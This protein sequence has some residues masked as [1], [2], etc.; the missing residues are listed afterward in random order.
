MAFCRFR[1]LGA[2]QIGSHVAIQKFDP[3]FLFVF[4]TRY[5]CKMQLLKVIP[6]SFIV[7]YG[8]MLISTTRGRLRPEMR[9]PVDR[10]TAVF[11]S[12]FV[13]NY[14]LS[15]NVSTFL[16]LISLPKRAERRFRPIGG[17]LDRK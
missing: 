11:Y 12:S 1:P 3:G 4:N 14:R 6:N 16:V 9:S 13:D 10:A 7:D 17:V 8:G 5:V 15:C 2:T